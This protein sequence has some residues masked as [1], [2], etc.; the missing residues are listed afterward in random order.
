MHGLLQNSGRGQESRRG[1][2]ICAVVLAAGKSERFGSQK[3]EHPYHDKPLLQ[4]TLDVLKKMNLDRVLI[5]SKHLDISKFDLKGFK[6]L[7]NEE[8]QK[9]LSSSVKLAIS[10]CENSDAILFFL[11]DMPEIKKDLIERVLSFGISHI[12]FPHFKGIK[13]FPVLLPSSYF[14]EAKKIEGDVGLRNVIKNHEKDCITFEDGWECV[15]D[16]DTFEDVK[17]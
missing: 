14:E 1:K 16:I 12:T 3:L 2:M 17:K 6:V 9:G 7:M 13:G 4:W 5:S 10:E 8:A 15:Y 11:G